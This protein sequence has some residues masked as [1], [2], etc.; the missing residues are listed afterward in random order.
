MHSVV[1][2]PGSFLLHWSEVFPDQAFAVVGSIFRLEP[3][4]DAFAGA[5]WVE[6]IQYPRVPLPPAGQISV[7]ADVWRSAVRDDSTSQHQ[8][9]LTVYDE[10]RFTPLHDARGGAGSFVFTV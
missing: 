8:R 2:K 4:T 1:L 7:T 5:L 3:E 6:V 9:V 10:L